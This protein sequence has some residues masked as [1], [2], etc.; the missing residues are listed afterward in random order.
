MFKSQIAVVLFYTNCLCD[1]SN[2]AHATSSISKMPKISCEPRTNDNNDNVIERTLK[3]SK[4]SDK[5]ASHACYPTSSPTT[6]FSLN[7]ESNT[8]EMD[9]LIWTTITIMALR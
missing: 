2:V 3:G 4:K 9:H 1:N 8:F 5:H 6:T 7:E